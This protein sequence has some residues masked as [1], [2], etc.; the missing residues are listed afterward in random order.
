MPAELSAHAER[1]ISAPPEVVYNTATDPHRADWLPAALR[2]DGARTDGSG[3]ELS[4]EWR[5]DATPDWSARLRVEAADAGGTR[6][7]LDVTA[8]AEQENGDQE[9]ADVADGSLDEL[10]R[11]VADN[12]TAG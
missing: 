6:V 12:L 7:R 9:L 10:S 3:E 1:G 4:A 2:H 8:D 5:S 11:L